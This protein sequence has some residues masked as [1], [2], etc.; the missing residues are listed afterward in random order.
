[1]VVT[2]KM[3]DEELNDVYKKLSKQAQKN[4]YYL[5][6]QSFYITLSNTI[7]YLRSQNKILSKRNKELRDGKNK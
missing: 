7:E 6:P 2:Y 1:M 3:E 4:G 5:I